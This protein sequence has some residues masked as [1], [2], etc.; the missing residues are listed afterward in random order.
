MHNI[1]ILFAT[2]F[3]ND[4]LATEFAKLQDVA[5]ENCFVL[6]HQKDGCA[7]DERVQSLPHFAF[8][9]KMV[10]DL[11]YRTLLAQRSLFQSS[12]VSSIVVDRACES[13]AF[14]DSLVPGSNHFPLIAFSQKRE[15][16]F[17]WYIEYDV[18]YTGDWRN[19]FKYF[20]DRSD[21]L[22]AHIR[23]YEQE[24]DWYWWRACIHPRETVA[25]RDRLR[26]FNPI[27]RISAC[28]LKHID[29]MHKAGWVGHHEVLVPT[30]LREHGFSLRD[31]GGAGDFVRPEDK[32]RFYIEST[33]QQLLDG[34]LCWRNRH[35][36]YESVKDKI[37]HPIKR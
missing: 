4:V 29:E 2:H 1:A 19:F 5:G 30:L 36:G 22:S 6:F 28:A 18:R 32:E 12:A 9:T 35:E 10:G 13:S 26:S 3:F 16:D 8:S 17:Y 34:S 27:Y 11:G 23:R 37:F 21:L 33:T 15:F 14:H 31:F 7:V 25:W 20:S 24:P